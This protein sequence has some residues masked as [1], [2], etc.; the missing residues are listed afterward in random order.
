MHLNREEAEQF[1]KGE[2]FTKDELKK[3]LQMMGVPLDNHQHSKKFYSGM[4]N[5]LIYDSDKRSKI[6]SL[7]NQDEGNEILNKK[8]NRSDSLIEAEAEAEAAAVIERNSN[9]MPNSRT[10]MIF[11]L[12]ESTTTAT[13]QLDALEEENKANANDTVKSRSLNMQN[14][15]NQIKGDINE[16]RENLNNLDSASKNQLNGK[17]L[18][19]AK[20]NGNLSRIGGDINK[21]MRGDTASDSQM[22]GPGTPSGQSDYIIKK[23]KYT[24]SNLKKLD[25]NTSDNEGKAGIKNINNSNN[26]SSNKIINSTSKNANSSS[27]NKPHSNSNANANNMEIDDDKSDN[28]S[29]YGLSNINDCSQWNNRLEWTDLQNMPS[30]RNSE[31]RLTEVDANTNSNMNKSNKIEIARGGYKRPS[32]PPS[33][34]NSGNLPSVTNNIQISRSQNRNPNTKPTHSSNKNLPVSMDET[35]PPPKFTRKISSSSILL[36]QSHRSSSI[37]GSR[38]NIQEILERSTPYANKTPYNNNNNSNFQSSNR[39]KNSKNIT[40]SI[41]NSSEFR[42]FNHQDAINTTGY[43]P[44]NIPGLSAMTTNPSYC[45]EIIIYGFVA[46]AS[47]ALLYTVYNKHEEIIANM[48]QMDPNLKAL[49]VA[50]GVSIMCIIIYNKLNEKK[51]YRELAEQDY[52]KLKQLILANYESEE[53]ALGLFE[54]SFIRNF[55]KAHGMS[56]GVY[57]R[58]VLP[59]LKDIRDMNEE[60][61]VKE[62]LIQE[63]MHIVWDFIGM[64]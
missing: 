22:N 38:K 28:A 26:N 55:S 20:E 49:C 3:R 50:I 63:Q 40:V 54:S 14:F 30:R 43:V 52:V 59:F 4:Y 53:H 27:N 9:A 6:Q 56:E 29:Y 35:N 31:I 7:L 33:K 21:N 19:F 32:N 13:K 16:R 46:I 60:I 48:K 64:M 39:T 51:Y 61:E 18:T 41:R 57:R 11:N 44:L 25:D 10:A 15:I 12:D 17:M 24:D 58:N 23:L 2:T 8:R 5:K 45:R 34:N 42:Q 1:T 47:G 37:P 36:N 62:V